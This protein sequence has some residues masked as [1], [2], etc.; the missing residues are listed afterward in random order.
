MAWKVT[1]KFASDDVLSFSLL[2][3][4]LRIN[5]VNSFKWLKISGI[6]HHH[7]HQQYFSYTM[8]VSV[9]AGGNLNSNNPLQKLLNKHTCLN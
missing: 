3:S 2:P 6:E 4:N 1:S 8:A 7:H 5:I 9:I